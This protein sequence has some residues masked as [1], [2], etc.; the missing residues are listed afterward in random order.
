MATQG[1][2][3]RLL[4]DR[5]AEDE[6]AAREMLPVAGVTDAIV[7]FHAQQAVEKSL[8]AVLAAREIDFPF[9]HDLDALEELCEAND[10]ALPAELAE[11]GRLTPY[12]AR[13]RYQ[14]ADP[15]TI[16]RATALALAAAAVT[17]ARVAIGS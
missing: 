7:A 2:L 4:L 13:A 8:K 3:A 16:E 10:I 17:W 9:T 15:D 12:A 5:A 14:A 11:A 6:A 1:D